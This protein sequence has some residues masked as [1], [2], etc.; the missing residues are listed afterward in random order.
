MDLLARFFNNSTNTVN[1]RF[2]DSRFLCHTTHQ[3]LHK[4]FN[5]LDSNKLFQI[6]MDGPNVNLKFMKLLKE[7]K[8]SNINKYWDLWVTHNT[9]YI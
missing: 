4:Q 8:M 2:C 5:E 1:T 7:I 9:C 3:D 6:S